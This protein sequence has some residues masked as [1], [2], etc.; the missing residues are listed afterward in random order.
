MLH[1]LGDCSVR[2]IAIII[3]ANV[4]NDTAWSD[5]EQMAAAAF[6][7]VE[8]CEAIAVTDASLQIEELPQ[9]TLL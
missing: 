5:I 7:Q 4:P 6:V 2:R 1:A 9:A 8:D 3:A